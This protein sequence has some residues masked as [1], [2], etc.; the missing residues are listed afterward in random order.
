MYM[1]RTRLEMYKSIKDR[2]KYH[3]PGHKW[4]EDNS[5]F[6]KLFKW[7]NIWHLFVH[8]VYLQ[9]GWLECN[10]CFEKITKENMSTP[11]PICI[12]TN[13]KECMEQYC[14][15][16]IDENITEIVC[17]T[18]DCERIIEEKVIKDIFK[19]GI[20]KICNEETYL[21]YNNNCYLKDVLTIP[22]ESRVSCKVLN[23]DGIH[24]RSNETD[25]FNLCYICINNGIES[26]YCFKCGKF[27]SKEKHYQVG[28][29]FKNWFNKITGSTVK[30][31]KEKCEEKIKQ[32]GIITKRC[33]NCK[34]LCAKDDSCNHVTCFTCK[35]EFNWSHERKWEGY[36]EE[37]R[38]NTT[39][40]R[41]W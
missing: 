35:F 22:E 16:K 14:K 29:R 34:T 7:K 27:H 28:N 25:F 41:R 21:K 20:Q 31:E 5:N 2:Y 1:V 30:T 36:A 23:C 38:R 8:I 13:C 11:C 15:I 33:P 9:L 3:N 39:F 4:R 24:V 6:F 17:P 19:T 40:N 32:S 26:P 10:I 37:N 12:K 18:P